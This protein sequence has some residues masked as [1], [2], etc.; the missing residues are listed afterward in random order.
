MGEWFAEKWDQATEEGKAAASAIYDGAA[1]AAQA[2]KDAAAA[3]KDA[4]IIAADATKDAVIASADAVKRAVDAT[5]T[6][7]RNA[8]RAT[9]HSI[10]DASSKGVAAANRGARWVGDRV[11]NVKQDAVN[12]RDSIVDKLEDLGLE[13][14]DTPVAAPITPCPDCMQDGDFMILNEEGACQRIAVGASHVEAQAAI[15]EAKASTAPANSP[16]CKGKSNAQRSKI[17][18]YTNGINTDAVSHCDTLKKLAEISCSRVVGIFNDTEGALKDAK[19]TADARQFLRDEMNGKT[20]REYNGFSPSVETIQKTMEIELL[21]G[22]E[23]NI[24]AH[25]EGGANTSLGTN[26]AIQSLKASGDSG[27]VQNANITSMGSAAPIWADG[28]NYNHYIHVNDTTPN[29]LGL[30][31]SD[32][33]GGAGSKVLRFSGSKSA[34]FTDNPMKRPYVPA[35]PVRDHSITD[36]YFEYYNVTEGGCG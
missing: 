3:A 36:S 8:A 17:Q 21:S 22:N 12:V 5:D 6:V 7:L 30:G 18:Y 19:R 16:C 26:R 11:D 35:S 33:N 15:T 2:T 13:F 14:D 27:L 34:G 20:V 31:D 1:A 10:V 29:L 24:I 9:E 25:S 32:H 4:A 28:P 23:F